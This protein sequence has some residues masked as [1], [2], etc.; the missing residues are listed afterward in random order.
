MASCNTATC[1]PA[2]T[3]HG[4]VPSAPSLPGR[5]YLAVTVWPY[6]SL[7]PR[8]FMLLG[9]CLGGCFLLIGTVFFLIGAWPVAGFCGLDLALIALALYLNGRETR[10]RE[11]IR[12]SDRGLDVMRVA[13]SGRMLVEHL[14][15]G[16]IVLA[17]APSARADDA[18]IVVRETGLNRMERQRRSAELGRFLAPVE[19]RELAAALSAALNAR[20]RVAPAF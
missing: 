14:G 19:R 15:P 2:S 13:P 1:W 17:A 8:G 5:V 10:R 9:F 18:P 3:R 7:K 4:P 16:A 20:L 11:H 12:V 6:R